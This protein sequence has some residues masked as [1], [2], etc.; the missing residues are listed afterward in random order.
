MSSF[1]TGSE[2]IIALRKLTQSKSLIKS[3]SQKPVLNEIIGSSIPFIPSLSA[4]E[5]R[6]FAK[7]L[8]LIQSSQKLNLNSLVF[9]TINKRLLE[10][11][12]DGDDSHCVI[13]TLNSLSQIRRE[14]H[15]GG[16][17]ALRPDTVWKFSGKFLQTASVLDKCEFL[18]IMSRLNLKPMDE[19][20]MRIDGLNENA[21]FLSH[22]D[23]EDLNTNPDR[24]IANGRISACI[25]A[26][27]KLDCF[28]FRRFS[29][30]TSLLRLVPPRIE[31]FSPME[32]AN[33]AYAIT[34]S[35]VLESED[36]AGLLPIEESD[37][38]IRLIIQILRNLYRKR[39]NVSVAA[40]NQIGVVHYS[41]KNGASDIYADE[42]TRVHTLRKFLDECLLMVSKD[43]VNELK[44]SK[45]QQ[46]VRKALDKIGLFDIMKDEVAVGPFRLDFAIPELR[47]GIEIDGPYHYY[48]KSNAATAKTRFKRIVVEN[49]EQF[50]IITVSYLE[51]KE[52][53]DKVNFFDEKIRTLLN[54]S[55]KVVSLRSEVKR[56]IKDGSTQT[57]SSNSVKVR[58]R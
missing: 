43:T 8:L 48:Y 7:S 2:Y 16:P 39:I 36:E 11:V 34:A 29:T 49:Q 32:L 19:M 54:I 38:R 51:L 42:M 45:A 14:T 47:L 30:F 52:E 5:L 13:S 25:L 40:M 20:M 33:T 23:I 17:P 58:H 53:G 21:I 26:M 4:P 12:T 50:R 28:S 1:K 56:L 24:G 9:K 41:L 44:E 27:L 6:S 31:E 55:R 10:L 57:R 37:F 22:S 18:T 15:D 46:V 3:A 35:V